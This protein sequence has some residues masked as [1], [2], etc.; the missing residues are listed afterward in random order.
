MDEQAIIKKK[1]YGTEYP[2]IYIQPTSEE[3]MEK[4]KEKLISEINHLFDLINKAFNNNNNLINVGT[5]YT[6]NYK[7][8]RQTEFGEKLKLFLKSIATNCDNFIDKLFGNLKLDFA[9][10]FLHTS[11]YGCNGEYIYGNG[12]SEIYQLYKYLKK[13]K[14]FTRQGIMNMNNS[15]KEKEKKELK[16]NLLSYL[17][18]ICKNQ[19]EKNII[20]SITIPD[21]DITPQPFNILEN[22]PSWVIEAAQYNQKQIELFPDTDR[23]E[24]HKYYNKF[25]GQGGSNSKITRTSKKEILGKERCIYKK[26]GDRKQYLK[27]K[28]ELITITEYK[29]IMAAKNKK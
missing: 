7:E 12:G 10:N 21:D 9:H 27:Y 23:D 16:T 2:T 19:E 3:K 24:L 6:E 15:E 25:T 20:N 4:K 8:T 17:S 18:Q 29:K 22:Q 14:K 26:S 1:L 5:G 11:S 13:D 28:G